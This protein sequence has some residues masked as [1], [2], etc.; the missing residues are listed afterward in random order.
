[1]TEPTFTCPRCF[2][3]SPA[4]DGVKFCP[5]CGLPGAMQAAGDSSPIEVAGR[6]RTFLVSDRLAI[7]SI[8][9]VYRCRFVAEGRD[10]EGVF[11]VA[12]D[13]STSP[14]VA[15]EAEALRLLHGAP[16]AE[17]Y[18]PFLP[19]LEDSLVV[20]DG[21]AVTSRRANVLRVHPEIASPADELYTLEEVR[22]AYP[23]GLDARDMAW[24]W[25]RLLSVL[26]FA[27]RHDVVHGAVLPMH[28]MIEPRGHKLVLI[29]WCTAVSGAKSNPRPAP[30]LSAGHLPWYGRDGAEQ[31]PAS[32][33]LDISLAAR[34]M[35]DL[36]GGDPV[37]QRFP[38]K[39]DTRLE[40]YF[41]GCVGA[42]SIKNP[43]AWQ[44]LADFDRLI[45]QLWGP[46]RFRVLTMP[47]KQRRR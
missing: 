11:K 9:A 26:G 18:V 7:G 46:R 8:C 30:M 47:P 29:D 5:H 17:R 43:D 2:H 4:R 6:G 22:R 12:R 15:N 10:V 37:G 13:P 44:M 39:F 16:D 27:H 20:G 24:V 25:R 3:E 38:P 23:D 21:G 36:V 40:H 33:G 32:P 28:V 1:L 31:R 41:R 19:V 35:I 45:E 34:C 14:F 42:T